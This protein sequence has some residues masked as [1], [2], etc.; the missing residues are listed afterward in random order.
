MLP[1][2]CECRGGYEGASCEKDLDECKTN[3]LCT[4]TSI[5][6]NMPGWYEKT[7]NDR[8][9][10]I[11]LICLFILGITASVSLAMR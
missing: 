2:K 10:S 8:I 9:K 1:N 3:N 7:V 5:C 4:N 11:V 6:I